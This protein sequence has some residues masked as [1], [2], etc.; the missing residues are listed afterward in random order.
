MR[1]LRD[2]NIP[3]TV[4]D[5]MPVFMGLIGDLFPALDVPRK[6]DLDFEKHVKESIL[7]LK[8]QAEDNFVLKVWKIW[9]LDTLLPRLSAAVNRILFWLQLKKRV[10]SVAEPR[11]KENTI[12]SCL[13][14][15]SYSKSPNGVSSLTI[16]TDITVVALSFRFIL[17]LSK[18]YLPHVIMFHWE[19]HISVKQV[20][21][22]W[23]NWANIAESQRLAA[24][25]VQVPKLLT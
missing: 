18:S 23:M 13:R 6:R 16:S 21:R 11:M 17:V 3:K 2:F 19:I 12:T 25:R 15:T 4:T 10:R 7:D 14:S 5:D 24:M 20:C 8:L 22:I 9:F 1:A